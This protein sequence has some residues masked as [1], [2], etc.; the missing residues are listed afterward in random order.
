[1]LS[2]LGEGIL[3]VFPAGGG[4]AVEKLDCSEWSVGHVATGSAEECPELF[5]GAP[6]EFYGYFA[7]ATF[8]RAEVIDHFGV[9]GTR[10]LCK[11]DGKLGHG[12]RLAEIR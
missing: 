5:C 6:V 1:L 8:G 11:A 10:E 9:E 4:V 3:V 7:H 12:V 2:D